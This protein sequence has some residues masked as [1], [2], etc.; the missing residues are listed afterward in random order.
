MKWW[1]QI[2]QPPA[3]GIHLQ[4]KNL[5]T[6]KECGMFDAAVRKKTYFT[7]LKNTFPIT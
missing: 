5:K 2:A 7:I 3:V 6:G 4:D 1:P